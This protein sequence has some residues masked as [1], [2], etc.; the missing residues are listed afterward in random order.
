RAGI[1]VSRKIGAAS[2]ATVTFLLESGSPLMHVTVDLDWREPETLLKLLFPTRY[3]ATS[4]RF[5]SPF[6]SVLRSQVPNGLQAEAMWEAPFSRYL[7]VFD[8]GEREG[9]F[10]ATESKY[11]ASVREGSIGLSLVRSPR[12]TGFDAHSHAWPP[13]LTRLKID[14]PFSDLGTHSIR[15]A[16]GR[17]EVGLPRER[18]PASVAETLFTRPITY[19]GEALTGVFES[20]E[21]GD[22]LVPIWVKPIKG[23]GLVLRLHEVAGGR[24]SLKLKLREGYHLQQTDMGESCVKTLDGEVAFTP[25][26]VV[27]LRVVP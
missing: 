6:G 24:G 19:T 23:G 3:A 25:Y 27:S 4:A 16:V 9:F 13:H 10:L 5:G 1:S 17:Y 15:L 18:Q 7:A 11:G 21:G 8:E 12:V 14:S 26:E 22:T 20:L 2:K